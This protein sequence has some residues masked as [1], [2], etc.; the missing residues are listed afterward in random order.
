MKT[1]KALGE[2]IYIYIYIYI[3]KHFYYKER[4]QKLFNQL[5][6]LKGKES[7]QLSTLRDGA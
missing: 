2:H 4:R 7:E 6:F 5:C 3:A 1:L